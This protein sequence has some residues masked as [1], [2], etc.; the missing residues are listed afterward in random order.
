MDP[1]SS[2]WAPADRK[3]RRWHSDQPQRRGR[4][5]LYGNGGNGF[6]PP[7]PAHPVVTVGLPG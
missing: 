7:P 5:L 4:W 3:R 6:S 1:L 2:C